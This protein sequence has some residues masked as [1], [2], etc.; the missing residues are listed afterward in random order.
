MSDAPPWVTAFMDQVEGAADD[1]ADRLNNTRGLYRVPHGM[2][3]ELDRLEAEMTRA[4]IKK[5]A[6]GGHKGCIHL[7]TQ[8]PQPAFLP[9]NRGVLLCND[10]YAIH[11]VAQLDTVEDYTCDRCRKVADDKQMR[12]VGR[13]RGPILIIGGLCRECHPPGTWDGT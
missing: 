11:S 5:W 8:A 1:L 6:D 13:Q 4:A 10:C 2:S 7:A 12:P 3:G 9:M